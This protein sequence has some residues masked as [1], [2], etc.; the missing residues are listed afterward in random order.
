MDLT[1]LDAPVS[2][3]RAAVLVVGATGF[4]GNAITARLLAEGANVVGLSRTVPTAATAMR[5]IR[6]D[7][8]EATEPQTWRPHLVGIKSVVYCAGAL[9]DGTIIYSE[10]QVPSAPIGIGSVDTIVG[11]SFNLAL[12]SGTTIIVPAT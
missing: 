6:L 10:G 12:K 8:L 11:V 2:Q 1:I 3:D 9:Q 7:I 4:L 5:H